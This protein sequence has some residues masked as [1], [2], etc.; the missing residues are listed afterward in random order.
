MTASYAW[1]I[2]KDH[3]DGDDSTDVGRAGPSSADPA[4]IDKLRSSPKTAGEAFR[5]YDDDGGLDYSGRV[6]MADGTL[7]READER[8]A[9][10]PLRDFGTPNAGSTEI[11]YY[12][13]HKWV[14]L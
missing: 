7:A 8:A 2:T 12:V 1:L 11:R 14:R 13:G 3:M 5:L 10:G 9:F 6:I 4:L